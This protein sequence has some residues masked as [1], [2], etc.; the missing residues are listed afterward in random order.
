[1]KVQVLD[2]AKQELREAIS[3]YNRQ[4]PGLGFEFSLEFLSTIN[5]IISF[6]KAWPKVSKRSRKT[7][8]KRFPYSL[9]YRE[10]DGEILIT[11][12]MNLTKDPNH[13]EHRI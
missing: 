4:Y 10:K 2:V 1:M 3:Y 12:V 5:R 9:L 11:A 6:P 13:W 7:R 8:I